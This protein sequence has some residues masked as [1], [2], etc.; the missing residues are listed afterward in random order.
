[1]IPPVPSSAN[2][3]LGMIVGALLVALAMLAGCGGSD[4][5]AATTAASVATGGEPTVAVGIWFADADGRLVRTERTVPEADPLDG[6]LQALLAGP[7]DPDLIAAVPVG[8]ALLSARVEDGVVTVDL[9][10]EFERGYPSG[11]S[12]AEIAIAGPLVRTAAEAAGAERVLI[13]VAG[14]APSPTGAQID[15]SEPLRPSDFPD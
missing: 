3:R 15:Y 7:D 8:T 11:G 4:D 2:T 12:A 6:A 9:S 14:R 10:E 1:M 13:T 5:G